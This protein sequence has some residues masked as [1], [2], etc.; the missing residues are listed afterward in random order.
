MNHLAHLFLAG[1]EFDWL[2]GNFIADFLSP[3]E[4]RSMPPGIQQG[5]R[6]HLF[7]DHTIDHHPIYKNSIALIRQ[8][9][10]KYAPVVADIYYDYL[11]YRSWDYYSLKPVEQ[12]ISNAY[13]VL[14][15]HLPD[16]VPDHVRSRIGGMIE[17]DFL[18]AYS[19]V[20][21]MENTFRMLGKRVHFNHRLQEATSFYKQQLPLLQQQFSAVFPVM[22][23]ASLGFRLNLQN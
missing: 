15:N 10:G 11:L 2:T 9:Q 6:I 17:H 5:I 3:S 21:Y 8:S 19:S 14:K 22:V 13:S 12:F 23:E 16:Q 4:Q 1:E 18:R 20:D 7:I